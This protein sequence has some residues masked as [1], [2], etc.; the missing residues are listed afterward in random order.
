[1]EKEGK[2][3]RNLSTINTFTRQIISLTCFSFSGSFLAVAII[4]SFIYFLISICRAGCVNSSPQQ[5]PSREFSPFH[6]KSKVLKSES[7]LKICQTELHPLNS[8]NFLLSPV[9][10]LED[11]CPIT[12]SCPIRLVMTLALNHF[13]LS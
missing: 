5:T 1:M 11:G 4:I 6:C 9:S 10:V 7:M 13:V 3:K 2:K 8:K 12:T